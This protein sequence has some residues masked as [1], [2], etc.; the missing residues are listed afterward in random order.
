MEGRRNSIIKS[1]RVTESLPRVCRIQFSVHTGR[2]LESG[3]QCSGDCIP[4][5]PPRSSYLAKYRYEL[6]Q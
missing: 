3:V 2:A 4:H 5:V 6:D 1:G